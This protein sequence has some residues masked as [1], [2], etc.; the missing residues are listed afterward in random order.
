MSLVSKWRALQRGRSPPAAVC[1]FCGA[2]HDQVSPTCGSCGGCPV[3]AVDE[4]AV[5]ERVQPMCGPHA[6]VQA[7]SPARNHRRS[8]EPAVEDRPWNRLL[9]RLVDRLRELVRVSIETGRSL[10]SRTLH[11][12]P[13]LLL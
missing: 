12:S 2:T 8:P 4:T 10:V 1:P 6:E 3:V 11:C 5:F 7:R 13:L 9:D